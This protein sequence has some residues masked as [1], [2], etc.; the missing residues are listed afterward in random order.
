MACQGKGEKRDE[1]A[2]AEAT[3]SPRAPAEPGSLVA[4]PSRSSLPTP[5]ATAPVGVF[6]AVDWMPGVQRVA[7]IRRDGAGAIAAAGLGWLKI[8]D[9]TGREL[10]H[11]DGGGVAQVVTAIDVDGDG[12][13]EL[14]V[15]RGRGR[16]AMNAG[17]SIKVFRADDVRADAEQ[18][19]MPRTTR[20]QVI[21]VVGDPARP[22]RVWVGMFDSKYFVTYFEATRAD[23]GT[24]TVES[25]GKGRVAADLAA[26]DVDG[27]GATDLIA[28]QMYGATRDDPGGA[29]IVG[30]D[31]EPAAIPT[32]RGAR[33]VAVS[34]GAIVLT[35][36]W[37]RRYG[38]RARALI[39]LATRSGDSWT[40]KALAN[41]KGRYGY[42]RLCIADVDADGDPDAVAAGHG[43]AVVIRDLRPAEGTIPSL[44]TVDAHDV[45]CGD[46]DGDGADEVVVAGPTPGIWRAR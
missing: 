45:G 9:S 44:G 3:S 13:G 6:T 8:F 38:T 34:D 2:P 5:L 10:D 11:V 33:A 21:E 23:D 41:V 40:T 15:A 42:D 7:V 24:W 36:G 31:R 19:P 37:D 14:V 22:N 28:V 27:D 20:A 4:A 35:D 39:S 30:R 18:I 29:W 43:P 46:L 32:T 12:V 25:I 16:D 17:V 26:G 1:P